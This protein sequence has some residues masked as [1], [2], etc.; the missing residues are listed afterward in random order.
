MEELVGGHFELVLGARHQ[1]D[2]HHENWI[3]VLWLLI[4]TK[5]TAIILLAKKHSPIN[6]KNKPRPASSYNASEFIPPDMRS[7]V[8]H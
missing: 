7:Q 8:L 5:S 4:I 2:L 6:V 3:S 1:L